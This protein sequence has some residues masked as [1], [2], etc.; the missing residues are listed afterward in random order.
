M[1]N[2]PLQAWL[3]HKHN[4]GDTSL[5]VLIFSEELGLINAL[6]KAGRTP[7]KQAQ[8]QYFM[9][10]WFSINE[11]N[12][13][14]YINKVESEDIPLQ[15]HS[16]NLFAA[17]YVNELISLVLKPC[18]P[19]PSIYYAYISSLEDLARS[20][21]NLSI[22]VVLRKFEWEILKACGYSF[23]LTNEAHSNNSICIGKNY[24]FIP[25]SG[26]VENHTGIPGEHIN[27]LSKGIMV[28]PAVIKS[29][30]LIMRQALSVLLDGRTIKTRN[31]YS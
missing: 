15:F 5:K 6:Y 27:A 9:P 3:I 16:K 17:M 31:L 14:F 12:N 28:T 13:W 29:S 30:K 7:K 24:A 10:L 26:F 4:S 21:S 19:Y 1:I 25:G 22:E 11:K 23:S 18:D 8:L 20:E 2:S